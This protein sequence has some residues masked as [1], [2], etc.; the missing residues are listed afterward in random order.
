M[1]PP[2]QAD[3]PQRPTSLAGVCNS[4]RGPSASRSTSTSSA[5]RNSVVLLADGDKSI[6]IPVDAAAMKSKGKRVFNRDRMEKETM[7]RERKEKEEAAK[8][9]R[10]EAAE[11]G[12]IASRE[13][14]E[15]QRKKLMGAQ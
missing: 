5:N 7:E 10:A 2:S 15:R 8:K 11:R 6:V 9:A 14:A 4:I 13:W 3:A 1:P 12:R